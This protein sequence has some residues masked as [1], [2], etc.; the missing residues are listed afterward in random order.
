MRYNRRMNAEKLQAAL[1]SVRKP[2]H[3]QT[4]GVSPEAAVTSAYIAKDVAKGRVPQKD[5]T[6]MLVAEVARDVSA[7]GMPVSPQETKDVSELVHEAFRP[8]HK[9]SP[10]ERAKGVV[11]K[12]LADLDLGKYQDTVK[13]IFETYGLDKGAW[14]SVTG[15]YGAVDTTGNLLTGY[16][17]KIMTS[18]GNDKSGFI[19]K[20]N[21]GMDKLNFRKMPL[22]KALKEL[23]RSKKN[24]SGVFDILSATWPFIG[25]VA[26]TFAAQHAERIASKIFI[27]QRTNLQQAMNARISESLFMRDFEF[28]HDKPAGEIMEVIN[29]G[30][31]ATLDLV[32]TTYKEFLPTVINIVSQLPRQFIVGQQE[33]RKGIG[34][35]LNI[36]FLSTLIKLP[37]LL[38]HSGETARFMQGQRAEELAQW[39][40]VNTQLMTTLSG[41]ES[42]R[43]SGSAMA[44]AQNVF[45]TLSARDYIESGGLVKKMARNRKMN[46]AFDVLDVGLPLVDEI[47]KFVAKMQQTKK[48][49]GEYALRSGFD[50]LVRIM[51]S[52][53]QQGEMRAQFNGLTQMY[54]DQI[55]PDI[56]DIQRMEELLG[57]YDALDR[58]GGPKELAR[59]PVTKLSSTDIKISDLGYKDIIKHVSMDIPQGSFVTIKGPSGI[60]KTT[61]L[62]N[63]VGLYAPQEGSVTIGGVPIEKIKKYGPEAMTTIVGY[64][65]QNPQIME[66]M[67]LKENLLLWSQQAVS[68]EAIVKTLHDLRLDH[69]VGRLDSTEKHFSGGELRRIGIARA[70]LKDPRILILDEPTANLD[71]ASAKQVMT[72]V[73]ELRK[74]RPE[75][76][77]IAITHDPIFEKISERIID[78][79]KL[80]KQA[81]QEPQAIRTPLGD[82]Q[83]LEAI[84]RPTKPS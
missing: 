48:M 3:P 82:H 68:E 5:T 62:R 36:E 76:T 57:K 22:D 12:P 30:R 37:I 8:G 32:T 39:D 55:I 14:Q 21:E 10:F 35:L 27:E 23:G 60:G 2:E 74:K 9:K 84:A 11:E 24:I 71:E 49:T 51:N 17:L 80:K 40:K 28:L 41:L 18:L 4:L 77:V 26:H 53:G 16:Q 70:L 25:G 42:A 78:F 6:D 83:V 34:K 75:M 54:V 52:K 65:N 46:V 1:E 13:G 58:P 47:G 19:R 73:T 66:G 43:T 72:L 59:I 61:L 79:A 20:I 31:E 33:G 44:G 56:Q 81:G 63:L 45:E 38:S 67:T 7:S 50:A 64:A 15:I 69:L 29:R